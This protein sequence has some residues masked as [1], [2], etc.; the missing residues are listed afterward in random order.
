MANE[1]DIAERVLE[2]HNDVFADI[3]NVLLFG[4]KPLVQPQ[5]LSNAQ[6]TS[7]IKLDNSIHEQER[8][9][10]KYWNGSEVRIAFYGFE[11]QTKQDRDMPLRVISYDGATYKQ[12]VNA[13]IAQ[14]KA[15]AAR[16]PIYPAIT[17][18]LYFGQGLWT[19]PKSLLGC[20]QTD[21]PEELKPFL[22]DYKINVFE[23]P[24]LSPDTVELFQSD[25]KVVADFFVQQRI[26]K[27]YV[28]SA[29]KLI[30]VAEV[31]KL[32]SAIT[33]DPSFEAALKDVEAEGKESIA[34]C[35]IMQAYK[36]AGKQEGRQEGRL[37]MLIAL[38]HDGLLSLTDAVSRSGL[39]E[40]DFITAIQKAYPDF[41]FPA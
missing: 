36:N 35:D 4:G 23:I 3:V 25:F 10:A 29:Q 30:H 8:D 6:L 21:I 33:R 37:E 26:N 5:D 7:Q 31:M 22:Q 9:I 13:H 19:Q 32:F 34:M 41:V 17:L 16:S 27:Q 28:P 2:N 40:A 20:M 18:V 24:M 12:Q 39:Q 15:H 11:N 1:K 38:V 14:E